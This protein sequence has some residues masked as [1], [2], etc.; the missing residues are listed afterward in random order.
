MK[1]EEVMTRKLVTVEPDDNLGLARDI[2]QRTGF[3]HLLVQEEGKLLGVVSDR[4]LLRAI[5]PHIG[6]LA[7]TERDL[8]TLNKKIHQVMTR[9]L[10][11]LPPDAQLADAVAAINR[12][13]ISCIPICNHKGEAIG[14]V[15]WRD[16]LR[17]MEHHLRA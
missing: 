8:A 10:V 2:F 1:V 17:E 13:P 16:L 4:D 7:E 14:I 11:T 15:T 6:T 12:H 3:H 9:K 5:S